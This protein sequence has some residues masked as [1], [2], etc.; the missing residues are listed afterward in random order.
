MVRCCVDGVVCEGGGFGLVLLCKGLRGFV[1]YR[2]RS[3]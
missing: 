1:R 2:E 3:L